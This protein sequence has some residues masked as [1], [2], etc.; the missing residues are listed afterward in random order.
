[1]INAIRPTEQHLMRDIIK[2]YNYILLV[3][4]TSV[5]SIAATIQSLR[6]P[7]R[8]LSSSARLY[9]VFWVEREVYRGSDEFFV[10]F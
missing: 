1:M 2:Y 9:L 5:M 10:K 7:C 6:V 8:L 3:N 4:R